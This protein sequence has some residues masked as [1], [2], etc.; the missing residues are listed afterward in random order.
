MSDEM[1]LFLSDVVIAGNDTTS[2]PD[3]NI[4]RLSPVTMAFGMYPCDWANT[5]CDTQPELFLVGMRLEI[6]GGFEHLLAK[7][8]RQ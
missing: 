5:R 8:L 2:T 6:T 3:A 7:V 1:A 4:G